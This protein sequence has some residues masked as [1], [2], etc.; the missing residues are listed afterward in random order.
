MWFFLFVLSVQAQQIT[1]PER[2]EL[3]MYEVV[4]TNMIFKFAFDTGSTMSLALYDPN[5][6]PIYKAENLSGTIYLSPESAGRIKMVIKNNSS[7]PSRFVYRCPDV[8]KEVQGNIGFITD[9]DVVGEMSYVFDN[10][11]EKQS[12]FLKRTV[13]YEAIVSRTRFWIKLLMFAEFVMA[14]V[15]MYVMHKDLLAMFEKKQSI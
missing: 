13:E 2:E 1:I 8:N 5:S 12:E 9:T 4:S 6:H 7:R 14:S 11:A 10:L 15:G 3:V